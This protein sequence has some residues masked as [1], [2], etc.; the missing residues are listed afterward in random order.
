MTVHIDAR[1][2]TPDAAHPFTGWSRWLAASAFL[3]GAA[4]Q[5]AEFVLEPENDDKA[6][7]LDWWTHH[8]TRMDWSQ[9]TG[10]LAIAFLLAGI[11]MM[12]QLG[13]VDSPRIATTAAIVLGTAM[14]GLGLVH[15]IELAARIALIAGDPTGAR[16]ILDF[17]HPRLPGVVGFVMFVPAAAIGN[18]LMTAALWRSR[19]VPKVAAGLLV[20]FVA[21]DFVADLGVISHAVTLLTGAIVGWAIVTGYERKPSAAAGPAAH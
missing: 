12:W 16:A 13:R 15:G 4:L 3:T 2:L 19:F 21:L 18:L 10:I 6:Q 14:I 5:L 11:A 7:R 17:S 8:A 20:A 1:P 9:A